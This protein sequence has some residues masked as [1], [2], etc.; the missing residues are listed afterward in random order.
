MQCELT[1]KVY[2]IRVKGAWFPI[3]HIGIR[4]LYVTNVKKRQ[5][6]K[7]T[8]VYRNRL[9]DLG[10]RGWK[11]QRNRDKIFF[12]GTSASTADFL[13]GRIRTCGE[14]LTVGLEQPTSENVIV[15]PYKTKRPSWEMPCA[16]MLICDVRSPGSKKVFLFK[17]ATSLV[18][19]QLNGT[20]EVTVLSP[21][22]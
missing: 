9:D 21:V 19:P 18:F 15:S 1:D 5:E 20:R 4:T 22:I 11:M 2:G 17:D 3:R 14:R 13:S 12:R 10:A 6:W 8:V 7:I 16:F